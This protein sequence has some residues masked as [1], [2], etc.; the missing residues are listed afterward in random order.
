VLVLTVCATILMLRAMRAPFVIRTTP[1]RETGERAAPIAVSKA[2]DDYDTTPPGDLAQFAA[3]LDHGVRGGAFGNGSVMD[4]QIYRAKD[5]APVRVWLDR[6]EARRTE[7]NEPSLFKPG[8]N[9]SRILSVAGIVWAQSWLDW[10]NA[11]PPALDA[12]TAENTTETGNGHVENGRFD[13][14]NTAGEYHDPHG[15]LP[16]VLPKDGDE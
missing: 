12:Q 14:K 3:L 16:K 11:Q 4:S 1:K 10:Y 15:I 5:Y 8:P 13:G 6:K 9:N 7:G 2:T